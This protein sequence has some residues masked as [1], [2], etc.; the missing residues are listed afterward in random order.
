MDKKLYFIIPLLVLVLVFGFIPLMSCKTEEIIEEEIIE[1]PIEKEI[2]E[3]I[4]KEII[5]EEIIEE[6]TKEDIEADIETEYIVGSLVILAVII[7]TMEESSQAT[8]DW[9]DDKISIEEHKI[10][11]KKYVKNINSCYDM[12]LE[13]EPPKRFEKA[14]SLKGEA[15]KHY[16]NSA[17]FMQE[18]I[19]TDDM[20]EMTD[21]IVQATSEL[22][23]GNEY[24]K[25]ATEQINKL[26]E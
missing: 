24:F 3:S 9:V 13:L 10:I 21:Y 7:N 20:G 4:E 14:H 1:E 5:E 19:E 8:S 16:L 18:Y 22:N 23:L 6:V 26:T 15:M 25:K 2:V 11:A 17:T 12:Y